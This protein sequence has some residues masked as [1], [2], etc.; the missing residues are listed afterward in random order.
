MS[1]DQ[2]RWQS[3][4]PE[5]GTG[6]IPVEPY[7]SK[8]Y[9]E[10]EKE[11]LFKRVWLNV[12]RVEEIP[13]AG[14]YIVKDI[15]V[16]NTSIILVRG[17]DGKIRAFHN[18]CS[19]RGNKVATD[20]Q[21]SCRRFT[22]GF[23]GWTFD[24][25]GELRGVPDENQFYDFDK[26]KYGLVPLFADTWEGF[27]FVHLDREPQETLGQQLADFGERLSGFP[28][29]KMSV[30]YSW[31]AE[32]KCNWKVAM[33]AFQ[34]GYHVAF[35]HGR[36][37]PKSSANEDNPLAHPMKFILSPAGHRMMSLY[38]NP[39]PPLTPVDEVF[40]RHGGN[41]IRTRVVPLDQL[42][43]G[44]NPTMSPTWGFDMNILFPNFNML[45]YGIGFYTTYNWWPL[46]ADRTIFEV[47]MY[48]PPPET[49]VQRVS[50]EYVRSSFH[51]VFREDLKALEQMGAML[52]SGALSHFVLQD[53]EMLL[54]H[55]Y[56]AVEDRVGFYKQSASA[57]VEA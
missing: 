49:P 14:S 23:H 39:N 10:L 53:N 1:G 29:H 9:F 17:A 30:C 3:E 46:A 12:G 52:P 26:S 38:G 57:A 16:W 55:A 2:L 19:H 27:V 20:A 42:P 21:G 35:V 11:R 22:C 43:K 33:D 36:T 41:S 31:Q 5:M 54:R 50:Q 56:K 4:Y 25:Q 15:A 37:V 28:F 48:F 44:V 51:F 6:L 24:L 40:L 45:L 13:E 32:L 34:E 8:E 7:V 47:R 18:I